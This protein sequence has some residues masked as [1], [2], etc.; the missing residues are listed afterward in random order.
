[1]LALLALH[2]GEVL[3][4][5]RLIEALWGEHPPDGVAHR[6][7][8]QVSRLRT[9]LRDAGVDTATVERVDGGYT[10]R[11]DGV[12]VDAVE[13]ERLVSDARRLLAENTPEAARAA[14]DEALALWRGRP[15]GELTDDLAS[16]T[17]ARRLEDLRL[18]ALEARAEA[19]LALGR[20]HEAL[21]DLQRLAASEPLREPV[22]ALLMLALYRC[23][24]EA[25]ALRVY[26]KLLRRLSVELGA[27]PGERARRLHEAIL[28]HDPEI[29]LERPARPTLPRL[30]APRRRALAG[31]V[32][33]AGLAIAAF[34]VVAVGDDEPGEPVGGLIEAP[35][36]ENQLAFID[37]RRGRVLGSL[38]LA[39][40]LGEEQ[41]VSWAQ[42]HAAD[43]AVF[44]N[45]TL[46][47][48]DPHE[49]L[50]VRS[51]GLGI[52]AQS[53]AVG[54]G[55]VWVAAG[56]RPALLRLGETYADLQ[57][58]Y[59]LPTTVGAKGDGVNAVAVADGSVWVAQGE[60]HVLRIDPRSGRVLAKIPTPGA[61]ALAPAPGAIWVAGG[62]QGGAYRI[63]P[64]VNAVVA[65]VDLDPYLCCVVAGGGYAWALNHR[66]WKLSSEGR[67]LSGTPIDGDGANLA[68]T[69]TRCGWPRGSAARTPAS[70]PTTTPPG[71]SAPAAWP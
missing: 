22:H 51:V 3:T 71:R 67:V 70:V 33:A 17:A 7:D 32:L 19:D 39:N 9:A 13:A 26:D 5:D 35:V 56:D 15:L 12:R 69:G 61:A 53:M 44:A 10:L 45:G 34:V 8:V 2:A 68:W 20:H 1:V 36:A 37:L 63:D 49:R 58:R 47:K 14:A 55:S 66:V 29:A 4:R 30:R 21:G 62:E 46:L 60:R 31:A 11:A 54:L 41:G 65:R 52:T 57:E 25:D 48:I 43:L 50:V 18:T 59:R 38:S 64:A 27:D 16:Q 23:G 40:E 42:G 24:R 6:L 28:S